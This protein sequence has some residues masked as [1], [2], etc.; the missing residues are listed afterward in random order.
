[1]QR[2][3][4][5]LYSDKK[6][7]LGTQA[8]HLILNAHEQLKRHGNRD[9][10]CMDESQSVT[11]NYT[12]SYDVVN[13]QDCI[14]AYQLMS[15]VRC[16]YVHINNSDARS[17]KHSLTITWQNSRVSCWASTERHDM[18]LHE[19]YRGIPRYVMNRCLDVARVISTHLALPGPALLLR[20]LHVDFVTIG[21]RL[22][23]PVI[24][25]ML[26]CIHKGRWTSLLCFQ[27]AIEKKLQH[28][29]NC[30]FNCSLIV[31]LFSVFCFL[32]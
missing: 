4:L 21:L 15:V 9:W 22:A 1:M 28:W 7:S 5:A 27:S 24:M 20:V 6:Q 11:L 30:M 13:I 12:T 14:G 31:S 16:W 23:L 8:S 26:P 32:E 3:L 10:E 19:L 25:Y 18:P 2:M 29:L 17:R